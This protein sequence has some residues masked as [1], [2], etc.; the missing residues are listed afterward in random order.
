MR[1][2]LLSVLVVCVIGIMV[3]S[4]SAYHV[5]ENAGVMHPPVSGAPSPSA[6]LTAEERCIK[7]NECMIKVTTDKQIYQSGETVN[8]TV[9]IIGMDYFGGEYYPMLINIIGSGEPSHYSCILTH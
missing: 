1:Y 9:E 8:F 7:N 4:V 3:P 6:P 5:P 2:L